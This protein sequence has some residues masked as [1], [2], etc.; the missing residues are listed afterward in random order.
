M[1]THT[2]PRTWS[3]TD[4]PTEGALCVS[5]HSTPEE[6]AGSA[7][8]GWRVV[9]YNRKTGRATLRLADGTGRALQAYRGRFGWHRADGFR[10]PVRFATEQAAPAPAPAPVPEAACAV[11]GRDSSPVLLVGSPQGPVCVVCFA[12]QL[13]AAAAPALVFGQPALSAHGA[14]VW[15]AGVS[16]AD[17]AAWVAQDTLAAEVGC[18]ASDL[19]AYVGHLRDLLVSGDRSAALV[20]EQAEDAAADLLVCAPQRTVSALAERLVALATPTA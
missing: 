2:T 3:V 19:A 14:A 12:E 1:S 4:E 8:G 13:A 6:A 18:D 17:R 9:R 10:T 16:D 11:C 7:T 15:N 20:P 5:Y